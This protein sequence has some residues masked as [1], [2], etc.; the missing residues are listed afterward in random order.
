M[1][2]FE[3]SFTVETPHPLLN[4]KVEDILRDVV[5]CSAL[6]KDVVVSNVFV[7]RLKGAARISEAARAVMR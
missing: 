1:S 4:A 3:V 7:R 5:K 2:R 6:G